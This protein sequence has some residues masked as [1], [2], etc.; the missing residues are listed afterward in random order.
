MKTPDVYVVQK[1]SAWERYGQDGSYYT[2]SDRQIWQQ[3]HTAHQ[4]CLDAV[5]QA[6]Q[7]LKL[8]F[9]AMDLDQLRASNM[10]YFSDTHLGMNP[11]SGLV[12]SVGGDGT[13]LHAS[14]YVG[15]KVKLLGFNSSPQTN[16]S[17]ILFLSSA[18]GLSKVKFIS[19]AS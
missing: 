11:K 9:E 6:L 4:H 7:R 17:S 3:S 5:F 15:G 1:K 8:S 14:H 10:G 16:P 19:S 2:N 12:I 13:L 18:A